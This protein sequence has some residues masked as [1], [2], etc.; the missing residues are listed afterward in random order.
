[1]V[2]AIRQLAELNG[3][4]HGIFGIVHVGSNLKLQEFLLGFVEDQGMES[5]CFR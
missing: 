1:M 3:K 2:R 5:P 4:V